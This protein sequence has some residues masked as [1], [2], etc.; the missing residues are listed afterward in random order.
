MTNSEWFFTIAEEFQ[1]KRKAIADECESR[2]AELEAH[3]GSAYF[4]EETKAAREKQD[5]KL[6]ALKAAY[7]S[8]FSAVLK[9]MSKAA[10]NKGVIAPTT[11]ELN[12]IQALKMREN[13]TAA[14]LDSA[15]VTLRNN[16]M[17]LAVLQEIAQKAGIARGYANYTENKEMPAAAAETT[18]KALVTGVRD[19]LE[20]DTTKASRLYAEHSANLYGVQAAP[21][22]RPLF[23]DKTGCFA[24]IAGLSGDE[25]TAFCNSVD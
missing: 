16:P 9:A 7:S 3:R 11:E 6:A 24:E 18:I 17:C 8:R 12:I 5:E 22:K 19:F 15:A 23:S 2:L 10:E 1:A 21:V 4:T 13:I 20:S 14:E 25:L